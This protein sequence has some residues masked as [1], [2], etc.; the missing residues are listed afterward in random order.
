MENIYKMRLEP[1]LTPEAKAPISTASVEDTSFDSSFP[2]KLIYSVSQ[3]LICRKG[4]QTVDLINMNRYIKRGF[5]L[6][7]E[8]KF[9]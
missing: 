6:E 9:S 3:T 1:T 8:P 7:A 5:T 4:S 2:I